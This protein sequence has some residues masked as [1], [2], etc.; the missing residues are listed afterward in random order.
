MHLR[1]TTSTVIGTFAVIGALAFSAGGA[2][3]RTD[4]LGVSQQQAL[5]E[6]GDLLVLIRGGGGG[7]SRGRHCWRWSRFRRRTH[8]WRRQPHDADIAYAS[9]ALTGGRSVSCASDRRIAWSNAAPARSRRRHAFA[10][11]PDRYATGQ[12]D[13]EQ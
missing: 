5:K 4:S 13:H 9:G 2:I 6:A 3:A 7:G 10:R 8:G 12:H 11:S 1:F